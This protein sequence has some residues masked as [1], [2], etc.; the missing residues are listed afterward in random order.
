[1]EKG[2]IMHELIHAIGFY[3]MQSHTDRDLFVKINYENVK[4]GFANNFNTYPSTVIN[5]YNT[6]YDMDSIMRKFINLNKFFYKKSVFPDYL[7]NAF[8][9]YSSINTIEPL[10]KAY[11]TRI[12]QRV[13]LSP[14]DIA[15]IKNMLVC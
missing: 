13:R 14:G 3:H 2:I 11:L 8:S 15:R 9:K 7:R 12:G 1:M 5:N 6:P 4:V 10:D